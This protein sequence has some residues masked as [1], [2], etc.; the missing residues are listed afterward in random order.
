MTPKQK[1]MTG[2]EF[3]RIRRS[4]NYSQTALAELWQM[5]RWG[6]KTVRRW[7]SGQS[8]VS[9][10]VAF[11]LRAMAAGYNPAWGEAA[12]AAGFYEGCNEGEHGWIDNRG[13]IHPT[14]EAACRA[15]DIDITAATLTGEADN[16]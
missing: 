7:E 5:G 16:G 8:S 14:A 2:R 13:A 10:P 3:S 9:G 11:A 4:L 6:D 1:I 15:H 12:R